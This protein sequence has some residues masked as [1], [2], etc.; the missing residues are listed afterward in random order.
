MKPILVL[1]ILGWMLSTPSGFAQPLA[2]EHKQTMQM[3]LR[4]Q[5]YEPATT[6]E[7]TVELAAESIRQ[8]DPRIEQNQK[9]REEKQE[10]QAEEGAP[11]FNTK[12]GIPLQEPVS[13][14]VEPFDA[15]PFAI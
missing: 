15:M 5:G 13:N 11:T 1:S 10:Q 6:S 2:E 9:E 8:P 3:R 7:T 12:F 4:P 14:Q